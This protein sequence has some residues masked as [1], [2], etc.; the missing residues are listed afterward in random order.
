M[1]R[2]YFKIIDFLVTVE[3]FSHINHSLIKINN[4]FLKIEHSA[5]KN[6]IFKYF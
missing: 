1:I 6:F 4:K 5:L 3:K 2:F